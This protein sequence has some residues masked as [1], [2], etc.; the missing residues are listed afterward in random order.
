MVFMRQLHAERVKISR[1]GRPKARVGKRKKPG[2]LQIQRKTNHEP[3]NLYST[4]LAAGL[5]MVLVVTMSLQTTAKPT[6]ANPASCGTFYMVSE[7]IK[8]RTG[9]PWPFNPYPGATVYRQEDGSFLVDD[10]AE[11]AA[12]ALATQQ[13]AESAPP[14]LLGESSDATPAMDAPAFGPDDLWLE[15][16]GLD[17]ATGLVSLRLNNT[18]QHFY[19]QLLGNDDLA[20]TNWVDQGQVVLDSAGT[21]AIAYGPVSM[22]AIP[23]NFFRGKQAAMVVSIRASDAD[24]AKPTDTNGTGLVRG[25]F[26][27]G[28]TDS[29]TAEALTVYFKISGSATNG[30]NYTASVNGGPGTNLVSPVTI[31][32]SEHFVAID[33]DPK[34]DGVPDFDKTVTLTLITSN[35]YVI[36]TN[37]A[38]ATVTIHDNPFTVVA[39][40]LPSPVGIDYSPTANGL[41]VSVHVQDDGGPFNFLWL[42][43]NGSGVLTTQIWSGIAGVREEVKVAI[44]QTNLIGQLTNRAGFTNG[45]VFFSSGNAIGWLSADGSRSDLNWCTLTNA[46]V[47][48]ALNL[49]GSLYVDRTGTWS[50]QLIAV[51]SDFAPIAQNKGV[52]RIDAHAHP[53][54]ITNILTP[55]LEGIITLT[56]DLQRWR[57]WAG[58]ILTGDESAVPQPLIYSIAANGTFQSFAFGIHA[59]DFDIIST[60]QDLYCLNFN[61]SE[62]Q[63]LKVS[64]TV[65]A[66]Y[67]GDLLITDAGEIAYPPKLFI[68]HWDNVTTN[69]IIRSVNLPGTLNGHYNGEF[70]HVT[71]APINLPAITP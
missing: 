47:T 67:V 61:D 69:F 49:R 21:N 24:A 20:T 59:E 68:L 5:L 60:N 48:N 40:N 45:D 11:A 17:N 7:A 33:I 64:R 52:W 37:L 32:A 22:D 23:N 71:F 6:G 9:P 50:N 42:G 8:G 54:L 2:T 53:T 34:F 28:R 19:Y 29:L 41:I 3:E 58:R 18:R 65:L 46:A 39:T 14:L 62:S 15:I 63:I 44:V 55:H 38:A 36:D 1:I 25:Q 31:P 4:A 57:P 13:A 12:L 51:T 16:T 66:K 70:E 27:I 10:R 26:E 30:V 35:Y 43:T 56:N